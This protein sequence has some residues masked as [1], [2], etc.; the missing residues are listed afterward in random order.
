MIMMTFAVIGLIGTII[1]GGI[2]ILYFVG[3]Y[4]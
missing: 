4:K 1:V 2:I 3:Y